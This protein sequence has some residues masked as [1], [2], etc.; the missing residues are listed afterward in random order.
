[1]TKGHEVYTRIEQLVAE[2]STKTGGFRTLAEEY[3]QPVGSVR[4][5]YYR[6]AKKENGEGGQVPRRT[7]RRETT[8]EHALVDA[9]AALKRAIRDV[10]AEVQAARARAERATAEYQ[11]LQASA[12]ERK[13]AIQQ[14]LDMLA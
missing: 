9:R 12:A 13:E 4:A 3:G 14:R 1:M 7:R 6:F 2:G 10:D 5:T 11:A 8:A